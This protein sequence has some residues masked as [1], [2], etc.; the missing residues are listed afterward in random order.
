MRYAPI[1]EL[2][3]TA[4]FSPRLYGTG[5]EIVRDYPPYVY[6]APYPAMD[7]KIALAA[8]GRLLTLEILDEDQIREFISDNSDR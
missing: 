2:I 1:T 8:P 7:A 3:V 4:Y 6:L 5:S